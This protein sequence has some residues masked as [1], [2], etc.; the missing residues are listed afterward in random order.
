MIDVTKRKKGGIEYVRLSDL[1][2][3]QQVS[4]FKFLYSAQRPVIAGEE[5]VAYYCDYTVWRKKYTC[6]QVKQVISRATV[7]L[8]T[9]EIELLRKRKKEAIVFFQKGLSHLKPKKS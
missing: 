1:T 2:P 4:F 5:C 3:Q 6:S 7:A 9:S 8:T